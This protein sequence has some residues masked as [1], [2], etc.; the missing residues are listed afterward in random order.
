V[1]QCLHVNEQQKRLW[2]GIGIGEY[3]NHHWKNNID[4]RRYLGI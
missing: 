3:V 4:L 1:I 2:E